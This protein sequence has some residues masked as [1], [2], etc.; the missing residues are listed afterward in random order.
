MI[1]PELLATAPND[2]GTQTFTPE[3]EP[4]QASFVAASFP[5]IVELIIEDL[6]DHTES[7]SETTPSVQIKA[8]PASNIP[9]Y[10]A[11]LA[12]KKYGQYRRDYEQISPSSPTH[13]S[14]RKLKPYQGKSDIS[15]FKACI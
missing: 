4:Y 1:R 9:L 14:S 2:N 15:K 6:Q 10:R 11:L 8:D 5:A 13:S 7:R 12:C 3:M